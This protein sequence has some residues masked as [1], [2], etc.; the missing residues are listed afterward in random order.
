MISIPPGTGQRF[1]FV[2]RSNS[3]TIG[4]G[5]LIGLDDSPVIANNFFEFPTPLVG[6]GLIVENTVGSADPLP[7][8]EQGVYTCRMPLEGGGERE[9]NIGIY[10][11]GFNS[12]LV[13]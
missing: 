5:E 1:R 7:T 9:I 11:T 10:P 13:Q 2:C 12:E 8:S 3:L 6:G 4:V